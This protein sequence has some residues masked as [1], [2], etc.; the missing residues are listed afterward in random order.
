M[1]FTW[2]KAAAFEHYERNEKI[3][4]SNGN[5]TLETNVPYVEI[6]ISGNRS[7]FFWGEAYGL[8]SQSEARVSASFSKNS[9]AIKE[10]FINGGIEGIVEMVE[11]N[12]LGL[13]IDFQTDTLELFGDKFN[14]TELFYN[15]T[16]SSLSAS[17]DLAYIVQSAGITGYSQSSLCNLLSIYGYYAPKK[18]TIYEN[19]KRLGV[20]ETIVL[21]NNS[22]S[23]REKEFRPLAHKEYNDSDHKRYS[24]LFKEA[25]VS[26]ASPSMNWVFLSSGW[27]STSILSLLVREFGSSKVRAVV[28][29]MRYSDRAGVINQF[30]LT[31]AI[32]FA[33]YYNV[34]L[35]VIELDL[36]SASTIADWEA[37]IPSLRKQH[38][39]SFSAYN[40]YKLTEYIKINGEFDDAIFAGEIS[41]GIHNF[42]FSQSA[43]VLEHPVLEFREYSDKMA[44]YLYGPTFFKS[45][46]EGSESEDFV[47]KSL[48]Q[49]F[50][51][52]SFDNT[53][54]LSITEKRRKY[55]LSMF[56][57]N[58][59]MPFSS[60]SGFSMLTKNGKDFFENYIY[61]SYLSD[62]AQ[63]CT[64]DTIYSWLL[65]LYNSFHWQGG[66]VRCFGAA[67]HDQGGK[68]KMPFWDNR[69][70]DFLS[71]MPEDWGRGLEM[72]PTKYPLKWS[73]END[74]DYPMEFQS[75]PHSYLYDVDP[76]FNHV[77]E[78]LYGSELNKLYKDKLKNFDYEDILDE[79]YFDIGYL[80]TLVNSYLADEEA[81]GQE[82]SDL[83]AIST[84][85]LIGW[86]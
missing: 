30:E 29:R 63:D 74:F 6:K 1:K 24:Q 16:E 52:E 58:L 27:D 84:L 39:Y 79:Q 14:R 76:E 68:I 45:V 49:R 55:L 33:E 78:I 41:D 20:G 40:F 10:I 62:A 48:K 53:D 80:K 31:R 51:A 25:V 36:T 59:R 72:L 82:R 42:G 21:D 17:I 26:R 81:F 75:G 71:Q 8:N 86:Y 23:V 32:K 85:S 4:F 34:K 47:Y 70:H 50:S 3:L 22:V 69:M 57:R 65:H 77:S 13:S 44:T 54:Q 7:L 19:I 18:E 5:M 43:T 83:M 60:A 56:N 73:L 11:G 67:L 46:L 66:T 61:D 2:N 15:L 9:L 28:G 12:Y 37:M 35:D 38:I 64:P